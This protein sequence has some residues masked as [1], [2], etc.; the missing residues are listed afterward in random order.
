MRGLRRPASRPILTGNWPISP[1]ERRYWKRLPISALPVVVVRDHVGRH[2]SFDKTMM[3]QTVAVMFIF[4]IQASGA[5]LPSGTRLS[6]RLLNEVSSS[7]SNIG[8]VVRAVL[9]APVPSDEE[10]ALSAGLLVSGTVREV[11]RHSGKA[12]A[13]LLIVLDRVAKPNAQPVVFAAILISVDNARESIEEDGSIRG[14]TPI[15]IEPTKMEDV[16][17]LAAYAH[18]LILA[19]FEGARLLRREMENPAIDYRK[20]VEMTLQLTAPLD[21]DALRGSVLPNSGSLV[22]ANKFNGLVSGQP[23]HT[24]ADRR[25]SDQTNLMFIGTEK[26]LDAAFV[27]AGWSKAAS[28]GTRADLRTF[29]A[30]FE[31]RGYSA[32]PV[33]TLLL[34]GKTPVLVYEKQTNTFSKRHHIRIWSRPGLFEGKPVWLGAATHDIGIRFS[35]ECRCFTHQVESNVDLEREK[36]LDDLRFTRFVKS[37]ALV[38]RPTAQR[39]FR[40]AT[41][42]KLLSDGRIAVM[43]LQQ[44]VI[45]KQ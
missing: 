36:I 35:P 27:T 9:I 38:Q 19:A 1:G 6:V 13:R 5:T 25:A 45:A 30:M 33:S 8:D 44:P 42:D 43:E 28:R 29:L 2:D 12:P 4:V 37:F 20:G 11:G 39:Q 24:E 21:T 10:P 23:L 3:S 16:L 26:D 40:N 15:R 17:M 22:P 18:P 34:D 14:L 41:G 32:A 7:R 31:D